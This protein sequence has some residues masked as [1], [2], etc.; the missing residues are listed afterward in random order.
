VPGTFDFSSSA[1]Q[2]AIGA[3]TDGI[4]KRL[5]RTVGTGT[6]A[7]SVSLSPYVLT[8]VDYGA[9]FSFNV[10]TGATTA[11]AGTTLVN[12]PTVTVCSACH[13]TPDAISHYQINGASFYQARSTAITGTN[14]T[15]LICHGTDRIADIA[16]MHSKNR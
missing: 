1:S 5:Y 15:C 3:S 11:A 13:D 12:S 14:E 9:G 2:T 10:G 16:V 7:A 4:D 8:G 6:Y